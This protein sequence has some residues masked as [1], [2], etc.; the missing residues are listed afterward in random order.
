M[1]CSVLNKCLTKHPFPNET[2][3]LCQAVESKGQCASSSSSSSCVWDGTENVCVTSCM[4]SSE[5]EPD[6]F[7]STLVKPVYDGD[8]FV[9]DIDSDD[10]GS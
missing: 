10:D 8:S 4:E 9:I 3:C 5:F 7:V 6:S 2:N 1:W